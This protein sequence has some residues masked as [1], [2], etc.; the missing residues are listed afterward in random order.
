MRRCSLVV[1]LQRWRDSGPPR[2]WR[3]QGYSRNRKRILPMCRHQV[4]CQA[5]TR[6]SSLTVCDFLLGRK[7]RSRFNPT[8]WTHDRTGSGE[9]LPNS[10]S[11]FKTSWKWRSPG[12]I[13]I[14]KAIS[15][16]SQTTE[17]VTQ[18]MVSLTD[19]WV[20]FARVAET[21][22]GSWTPF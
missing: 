17:E 10:D 9:G 8:S 4:T 5:A 13:F 6:L 21:P 22:S 15:H 18:R 19:T 16:L 7:R 20:R 12:N 3:D 2:H 14:Q 11:H 1:A